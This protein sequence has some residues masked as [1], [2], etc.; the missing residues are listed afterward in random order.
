M[1]QFCEE[2]P[3]TGTLCR[4]LL[5]DMLQKSRK[6]ASMIHLLISLKRNEGFT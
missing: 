4:R 6:V 3:L 2:K 5:I 1:Y